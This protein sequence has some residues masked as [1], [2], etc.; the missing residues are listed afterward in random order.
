MVIKLDDF[1]K[2]K[3]DKALAESFLRA[4][5]GMPE[6]RGKDFEIRLR[7]EVNKDAKSIQ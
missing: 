1:R 6:C 5:K 2:S 7:K 4:C 3:K